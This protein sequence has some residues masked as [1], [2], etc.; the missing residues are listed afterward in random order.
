MLPYVSS[1]G[2]IYQHFITAVIFVAFTNPYNVGDRIRIDGGDA[3]YVRRI[4]TYTTDFETIFGKPVRRH[5][6]NE[7]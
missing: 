7:F 6:T 5:I 3:M 2:Y 4:R 1:L